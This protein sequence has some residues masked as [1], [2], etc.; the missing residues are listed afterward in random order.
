M[1]AL[2]DS[3]LADETCPGRL[4]AGVF[5]FSTCGEVHFISPEHAALISDN[6]TGRMLSPIEIQQV[7]ELL[8]YTRQQRS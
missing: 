2:A 6:L 4:R 8:G 5:S 7:R 1:S 3:F